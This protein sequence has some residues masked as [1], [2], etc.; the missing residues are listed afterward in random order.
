MFR[1]LEQPKGFAVDIDSFEKFILDDWIEINQ[2]VDCVFLTT[3]KKRADELSRCFRQTRI[4]LLEDYE[5][6]LSPNHSTHVRLLNALGIKSCELAYLSCNYSFL[7][8]THAFLSGS[9]WITEDVTYQQASKL[10]DLVIENMS[11]FK[12][13]LIEGL[14]GFCGEMMVIP[15]FS[16]KS[17]IFLPVFF[18]VDGVD[19]PFYVLGRYYSSPHFNHQCHPYSIAIKNNKKFGSATY[20]VFNSVF[21]NIY[22][23]V[24]K[25]L[26][27][28]IQI[29]VVCSVPVKPN[30]DPR[31]DAILSGISTSCGVL[32][33]GSSFTCIRD[34]PDQKNLKAEE[35]AKNIQGAFQFCGSLDGKT[36]VLI[37][38]V[39]ATG[40]TIQECV[41]ELKKHKAKQVIVLVLAINQFDSGYWS[42]DIPHLQCSV[43]GS[44]MVLRVNSKNR[45]FFYSC[46][47]YYRE[48]S[49][50]ISFKSGLSD[51]FEYEQTR[52]YSYFSF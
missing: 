1:S 52:L 28:A 21:V 20:G 51:L 43:C 14:S 4:I 35:R 26:K 33:A 37:D 11:Q 48:T 8:R 16:F 47:N 39:C 32:N 31:F 22:S 46:P 17:A 5:Y 44:T 3:N 41:R 18:E 10:P 34:Y 7:E 25:E 9:I 30:K 6:Y 13:D 23:N 38:D 42:S 29:D 27:K 12:S 49:P 50:T 15:H 19:V 2:S 24:I 45:E 36:V 40:A